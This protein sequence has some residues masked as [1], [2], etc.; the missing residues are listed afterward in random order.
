MSG[1]FVL[2]IDRSRRRVAKISCVYRKPKPANSGDEALCAESRI[3]VDQRRLTL[4]WSVST[5]PF[6]SKNRLEAPRP[7]DGVRRGSPAPDPWRVC[8]PLQRLAD[9][10]GSA[11]G[12]SRP[13]GC[14]EH[15]RS[16]IPNL[17]RR[18]SSP[19]LPNLGFGTHRRRIPTQTIGEPGKTGASSSDRTG[20]ATHDDIADIGGSAVR[21]H[22]QAASQ[23]S[24]FSRMMPRGE[25]WAKQ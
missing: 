4:A 9:P 10:S 7:P 19:I 12:C 24:S 11:P 15:R 2:L 22:I 25:P 5:A 17:S 6:R 8:R 1:R 3:R 18:P 13:S 20:A 21:W 16:H 23:C 14:S